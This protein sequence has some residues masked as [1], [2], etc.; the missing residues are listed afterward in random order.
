MKQ[1]VFKGRKLCLAATVAA[2]GA[3]ANAQST[4]AALPT[5]SDFTEITTNATTIFEAIAVLLL[6]VIGFFVM[7]KFMKFIGGRK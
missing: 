6:A 4:N 5:V 7:A 2:T 3:L 1:L